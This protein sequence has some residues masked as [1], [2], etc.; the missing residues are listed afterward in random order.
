MEPIRPS[1]R[2]PVPAVARPSSGDQRSP[3]PV[4]A[5]PPV[6]ELSQG[7]GL[8]LREAGAT[9]LG[10]AA[11]ALDVDALR[12]ARRSSLRPAHAQTPVPAPAAAG[13]VVEDRPA[14]LDGVAGLGVD[15]GYLASSLRGTAPQLRSELVAQVVNHADPAVAAASIS[16]PPGIAGTGSLHAAYDAMELVSTGLS[17]AH[18][19]GRVD[20][21]GLR[22]LAETWG[23]DQT[24]IMVQSLAMGRN[25][26]GAGG[27]VEA[28]GEQALALGYDT[29]AALAFTSTDALLA[30]H[31]PTAEAQREAFR[32]VEAFIDGAADRESALELNPSYRH[33]VSSALVNASRLTANGNGYRPD[34]LD[35]TLRRL[36]P[37]LVGESVARAGERVFN[38][39][40]PGPLDTLGDAARR[41]A[42]EADGDEREAWQTNA[43][44]AHTQSAELIAEN[45]G[46]QEARL[47]AFDDLN[48]V[49]AERRGEWADA[50]RDGYAL[51]GLPRAALGINRLLATSPDLLTGVL[52]RGPEG[53]ADLV[54][55][56]ESVA[57]DPAVPAALR[58]GLTR[59]LEGY[60]ERQT[61]SIAPGA[62]NEVG[63]RL[64][65]LLG[66][67]QVA[68]DRAVQNAPFPDERIR[69]LALNLASRVA[70]TAAYAALGAVSGPVGSVVGGLVIDE[71][72]NHVFGSAAPSEAE[73]RGALVDRLREERIDVSAGELGH[74]QLQFI[75]GSLHDALTR[76]ISV[77]PAGAR[78]LRQRLQDQLNVVGGALD[79]LDAFGRTL[80]SA[81]DGGQLAVALL[82][83]DQ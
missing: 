67:L 47:E 13:P 57:L 77:A 38:G 73:A 40:V 2:A 35:D 11:R 58:D 1:R 46:T 30:E 65:T 12:A 26:S 15:S 39:G 48:Q 68:A 22:R 43:S 25:A 5:R 49:L 17:E 63:T 50:E 59:G 55:L 62:A 10:G 33:A 4:A 36:G 34:A 76:Q 20:D 78:E 80:H 52:D 81:E 21:A 37:E 69:E 82:R 60:I 72:L 54:Q 6:D 75:Y 7:R 70:G 66:A 56:F 16:G 31:Y 79:G 8:A 19:E 28:L 45:L 71:T 29:A 14:L 64:G 53:R 32:H 51:S 44:L 27:V 74:E 3:P 42:E 24:A 83:R 41:V 9:T 61:A 23:A 18:R